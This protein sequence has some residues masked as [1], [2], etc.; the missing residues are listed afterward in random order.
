[1]QT[2]TL[3][4]PAFFV[5]WRQRDGIPNQPQHNRNWNVFLLLVFLDQ[6]SVRGKKKKKKKKQTVNGFANRH[7]ALEMKLLSLYQEIFIFFK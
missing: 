7:S 5:L 6:I 4:P 3:Q 1:M 2:E